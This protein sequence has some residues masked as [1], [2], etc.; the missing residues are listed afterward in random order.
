MKDAGIEAKRDAERDRPNFMTAN[1][2][3]ASL[4]NYEGPSGGEP[5]FLTFETFKVDWLFLF[6]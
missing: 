4:G 3:A 6:T 5:P 2:M 1:Y